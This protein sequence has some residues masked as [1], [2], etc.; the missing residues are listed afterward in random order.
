[1]MAGIEPVI[2]QI[3]A[4]LLILCIF[5]NDHIRG[6]CGAHKR[7]FHI[8]MGF[9]I[10]FIA[11][12]AVSHYIIRT[13]IEDHIVTVS[14]AIDLL[15]L[16]GTCIA[17]SSYC[18]DIICDN[19]KRTKERTNSYKGYAVVVLVILAAIILI[20]YNRNNA[21]IT[22]EDDI[23]TFGWAFILCLLIASLPVIATMIGIIVASKK[24]ISWNRCDLVAVFVFGIPYIVCLIMQTIRTDIPLTCIGI[25]VGILMMHLY[26]EQRLSTLD[27]L[28]KVYNNK[29]LKRYIAKNF[30]K[31]RKMY[32]SVIQIGGNNEVNEKYGHTEGD[33][34]L[35]DSAEC[36]KVA[37]SGTDIFIGRVKNSKFLL[38]QITSDPEI[39][40]KTCFKVLEL[41]DVINSERPYVLKPISG[42]MELTEF[43]NLDKTA[44]KA[45]ESLL[46]DRMERSKK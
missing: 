19:T 21:F 15:I 34:V 32:V 2:I 42:L 13:D 23:L 4:I 10:L 41:I 40:K 5:I 38:V 33:K 28:T 20:S 12:S 6:D 25:A 8:L 39:L 17:W 16:A 29:A 11:V 31:N 9:G 43:D 7:R 26:E 18:R 35:R 22:I 24:E 44:D 36:M 37:A 30:N 3:I 14:A 45:E 1:M 46:Y 27:P